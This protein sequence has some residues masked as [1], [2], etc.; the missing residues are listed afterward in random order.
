M[1]RCGVYFLSALAIWSC[2]SK[3]VQ[4]KAN[5]GNLESFESLCKKEIPLGE[6]KFITDQSPIVMP[7]SF[8]LRDGY[9]FRLS[10]ESWGRIEMKW[11]A[12]KYMAEALSPDELVEVFPGSLPLE[13]FPRYTRVVERELK[14]V[15]GTIKSSMSISKFEFLKGSK[16]G[17]KVEDISQAFKGYTVSYEMDQSGNIKNMKGVVELQD[18]IKREF[19]NPDLDSSLN[20][21]F[22]ED[23][24]KRGMS[25]EGYA[26]VSQKTL[27]PGASVS[28]GYETDASELRGAYTFKGWIKSFGGKMAVLEYFGVTSLKAT[29]EE[30]PIVLYSKFYLDPELKKFTRATEVVCVKRKVKKNTDPQDKKGEIELINFTKFDSIAL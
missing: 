25:S 17:T 6:D 14:N 11:P 9:K 21:M 15:E 30:K 5:Q 8:A 24:L 13:E 2:S 4:L 7:S 27:K 20:Q 1:K 3:K 12:P 16:T 22:S 19:G 28:N 26:S 18:K 23:S 29:P 10:I